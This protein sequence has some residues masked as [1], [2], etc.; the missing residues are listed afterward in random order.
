MR[1]HMRRF[2]SFSFE[3]MNEWMDEMHGSFNFRWGHRFWND[4]DQNE[5]D[6]IE[7]PGRGFM[8]RFEYFNEE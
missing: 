4:D 3:E 5:N 6:G 7:L 1:G 8:D 2:N